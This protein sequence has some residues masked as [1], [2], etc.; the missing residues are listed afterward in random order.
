MD[1]SIAL[2]QPS[3][4]YL[5]ILIKNFIHL[6]PVATTKPPTSNFKPWQK[7]EEAPRCTFQPPTKLKIEKRGHYASSYPKKRALIFREDL[8]GRIEKKEDENG[9]CVEGEENGEDD[10]HIRPIARAQKR[11][12]KALEDNGMAAYLEE[13]FKI[14]LERFEGQERV[15]KLFSKCSISNDETRETVEEKFVKYLEEPT[16]SPMTALLKTALTAD[17]RFYPTTAH[18]KILNRGSSIKGDDLGKDLSNST[19]KRGITSK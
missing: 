1:H 2:G 10:E 3:S 5:H 14:K 8:N 4:T 19:I 7:K 11:K 15:S 18:Y 6:K 16:L 17:D 9:K 13:A 12:L